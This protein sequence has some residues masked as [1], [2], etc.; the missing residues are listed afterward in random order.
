MDETYES[1]CFELEK[2]KY[3]FTP[4]GNRRSTKALNYCRNSEGF[5][6]TSEMT[7]S[8]QAKSIQDSKIGFRIP[9]IEKTFFFF[10]YKDL[11]NILQAM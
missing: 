7:L 4:F 1:Y 9:K 8:I 10:R 5:E 6:I 11:L 2:C 3:D